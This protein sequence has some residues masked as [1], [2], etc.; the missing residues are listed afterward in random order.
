ML[1]EE[2]KFQEDLRYLLECVETHAGKFPVPSHMKLLIQRIR[3]GLEK[4]KI[5]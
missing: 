1:T 2:Q 4:R 5:I 3:L